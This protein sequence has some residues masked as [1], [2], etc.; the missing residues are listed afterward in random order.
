MKR[1][2]HIILLVSLSVI[3]NASPWNG[4][5][6]A[7][8]SG[9][10]GSMATPY[11][12]GSGEE[13]AYLTSL[14]N[15]SPQ[16]ANAN[17][18]GKYYKLTA[19]IDL[20]GPTKSWTPIGSLVTT[21]FAGVFDGD[22]HI[23]TNIYI[24]NALVNQGLFGY[25]VGISSANPSAI[26]KNVTVGSGSITTT[27]SYAAGI[28]ARCQYAQITNCKN[29]I[30]VIGL[31]Y[32]GGIVGRADGVSIIENCGNTGAI[33]STQGSNSY[34]AGIAASFQ[35]LTSNGAS[36]ISYVRSCYNSGAVNAASY[37]GGIIG[38][39]NGYLTIDKCFNTAAISVSTGGVGGIIGYGYTNS[40]GV[41]DIKNCYNTG[42]I[43][44]STSVNP[45]DC[46]GGILG[47]V[48]NANTR[49]FGTIL[50][51]YNT[52]IIT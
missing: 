37:S 10:N 35:A 2:F 23:I 18:A 7:S 38:M 17:T 43:K 34:T 50:N 26:V 25:V 11:L 3:A 51:C 8:F 24:N 9:G 20:N 19:D 47:Y 27:L 48:G 14:A 5:V 1:I 12:I 52:G 36:D 33:K 44:A 39:G 32:T 28:A 13:L 46:A 40:N 29:A 6:A 31:S 30:P 21:A 41:L 4:T 42:A 16:T 45:V 15:A 49:I 22:N